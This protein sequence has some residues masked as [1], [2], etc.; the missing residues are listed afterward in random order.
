MAWL[1]LPAAL[2]LGRGLGWIYGSVIRYHRRDAL[3]ALQRAFPGKTRNDITDIA[4]RMYRNFGMNMVEI[5]RLAGGKF[6]EFQDRIIIE[7]R[8]RVDEALKRGRGVLILTAHFGNWDLL[9]MFTVKH[10][11]RLTIISKD[12]KNKTINGMWMFMR[13]KFGVSII[14]AHNS[15]RESLRVL[16]RNELLGFILDQNRPRSQ[17]IFVDFFGRPA[18]TSPGLAIFS[19][20]AK[21]PVVPVFIHRTEDGRHA[22]QILPLIEPP[23][24]R[25]PE[26]IRKATQEYTRVIEDQVRAHPEQWIW[27]H[28]RWKT[29]PLA[30]D[31]GTASSTGQI[32]QR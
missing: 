26:T 12:I 22:L 2:A 28:R 16:R 4:D 18:C 1:S 21:A 13:E 17:G 6:N 19:A 7:N 3:D 20:Q 31:T 9:G 15:A 23:A 25:E 5:L 10:N 8:E 32:S 11:Y 29:Q 24:N 27:L 14:P 30:P